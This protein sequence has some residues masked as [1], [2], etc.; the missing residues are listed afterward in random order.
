VYDKVRSYHPSSDPIKAMAV[1]TAAAFAAAGGYEQAG[2]FR[3]TAHGTLA[4]AAAASSAAALLAGNRYSLELHAYGVTADTIAQV[5]LA[6]ARAADAAALAYTD[7]TCAVKTTNPAI[8]LNYLQ[9][10]KLV[11]EEWWQLALR[12]SESRSKMQR[13]IGKRRVVDR[14]CAKVRREIAELYPGV[15]VQVAYG[16]AGPHMA[17]HGPRGE[18]SVPTTEVYRAVVR[19]FSRVSNLGRDSV[20][21]VDEWRTSKVFWDTGLE[22][23]A[24]YMRRSKTDLVHLPLKA[25]PFAK[26]AEREDVL[27]LH[28][29]LGEEMQRRRFRTKVQAPPPPEK[30]MYREV[31]GLRYVPELKCFVSRDKASARAIACLRYLELLGLQRPSYYTRPRRAHAHDDSDDEDDDDEDDMET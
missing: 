19:H 5:E 31:R 9:Q 30:V 22:V 21:I 23:H 4:S 26:P 18:L 3:E 8:L 13:Y 20:R 7:G 28:R 12:R 1:A 2:G 27:Q 24:V 6:G 11:G 10:V 25:A 29:Q 15:P 16:S 14:F 17:P